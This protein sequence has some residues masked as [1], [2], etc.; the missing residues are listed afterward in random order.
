MLAKATND[1]LRRIVCQLVSKGW[2]KTLIGKALLGDN[3]QA[4]VNNWL[5]TDGDKV[6]DF[7]LKPLS[8]IAEQI[9]YEVH[10]VFLPKTDPTSEILD[11]INNANETFADILK[12]KIDNYL[13]N[14]VVVPKFIKNNRGKIDQVLDEILK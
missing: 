3:G 9:G 13:D 14:K 10:V 1:L 8:N 5:K 7:G 4:H 2:N 11:Q 12:T 6:S